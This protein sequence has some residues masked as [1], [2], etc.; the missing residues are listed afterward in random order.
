MG[1]KYTPEELKSLEQFV[2]EYIRK[3]GDVVAIPSFVIRL[4]KYNYDWDKIT[5]DFKNA[6]FTYDY[7]KYL[8]IPYED[9]P[10]HI[11][12]LDGGLKRPI[13]SWRLHVGR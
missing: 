3:A 8:D 2:W 12:E 6:H 13:V 10:L 5:E 9:L 7:M 11:N 1:S 4:S